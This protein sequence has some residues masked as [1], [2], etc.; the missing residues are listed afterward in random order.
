MVGSR[1]DDTI[2]R[3]YKKGMT[4]KQIMIVKNKG[5]VNAQKQH[6]NFSDD[7]SLWP[8]RCG[9]VVVLDNIGSSSG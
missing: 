9:C 2:S 5:P 3:E 7:F 1:I 8:P 4:L 6:R